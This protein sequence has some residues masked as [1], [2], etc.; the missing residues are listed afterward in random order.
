[1]GKIY[2]AK[3]KNI[4][5]NINAAFVEIEPG[6]TCFLGLSEVRNPI[7]I[8]RKY[9]GRLLAED[10]IMVQV[11]KEAAKTKP[12]AVTCSPSL[13]GRYCV[14]S[15]GKP[16]LAYSAKLS[17][18]ARQ[19][20]DAALATS[21]FSVKEYSRDFGIVIRT[22]AK[23]LSEDYTPLITEIKQLSEE[24]KYIMD[25]AGHRT[26]YSVL[27]KKPAGYLTALR[28]M[29]TGQYDEIVT[30]EADI[31]EQLKAF[32]ADHPEFYLPAIRLYQD[33]RLPLYK[34]YAVEARLDEALNR[35]VWLKSGGY[36]IIDPTEALTVIDVNTGKVTSKKDME[37]NYF[38]MNME[39]AEE[40]ALQ[41]S[42]RNISGIIIVDFI[43]MRAEEHN[44]K[45]MA[46]FGD[47]LKRDAIKTKLVDIT[48]L[49][50][51]EI[52]RMKTSKPLR[53]Q[54]LT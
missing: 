26:C 11:R 33:D 41:L 36:L 19:R 51:V 24:L 54:L 23:E 14:I 28:D 4:V 50:L 8:N 46:H 20:I 17:L 2:I 22:N 49:G 21:D 12:A 27:L 40:I 38:H 34:L 6:V 44:K 32:L 10:E 3:V 48:P 45:L 37:E 35:K 47:L 16:G 5:K 52:T 15:M 53:E 30:D 18:K 39:A 25:I 7:L 29:Y 9:D 13:D 42:L 31:F 43:N 1:M